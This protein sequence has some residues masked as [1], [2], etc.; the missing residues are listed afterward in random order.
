MPLTNLE[1]PPVQVPSRICATRPHQMPWRDDRR[2]VTPPPASP[3]P[4]ASEG[5]RHGSRTSPWLIAG[6]LLPGLAAVVALIFTWRQGTDTLAQGNT[7]LRIA[8]QGQITERF[9][10]A[11]E[12][13]GEDD[14][15][16]SFG[17][18]YAL[19]RIMEDS[20]RD[21]SRIVAVLSAFVRSHSRVPA[22]GF[23][24]QKA[25]SAPPALPPTVLAV[26]RVL[27]DRP[28]GRDGSAVVDWSGSD[29]RGLQLAPQSA[30][31]G[32]PPIPAA[33]FGG[34]RL[35]NSDLRGVQ[36]SKMDLSRAFLNDARL[37]GAT[38]TQVNLAGADLT[39]VHAEKATVRDSV[40][41]EA[42]LRGAQ[43]TGTN[44]VRS[45][46][47][48]AFLEEADL[49]E[50][51]FS[52]ED[53]ESSALD[54]GGQLAGASL[55]NTDLTRSRLFHADLTGANLR[56]A[57]LTAAELGGANLC[58]S[59]LNNAELSYPPDLLEGEAKI[60]ANLTGADLRHADLSHANL[61]GAFLMGADL[62]G[63]NLLSTDLTG[64]TLGGANL[65][66]V[67]L[68][69]TIGLPPG[70]DKGRPLP[71]TRPRPPCPAHTAS[72]PTQRP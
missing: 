44:F 12:R 53:G 23:A 66:D 11:I 8:E 18:V 27:A 72:T 16:L 65:T 59:V 48:G 3:R 60:G 35:K 62:R 4:R 54:K 68:S 70:A 69:N 71:P 34:A 64:A 39:K 41:K 26:I 22:G 52:S 58:N 42:I 63:A 43:L 17:G 40:L 33:P 19:E 7:E 46:L 29:L 21:Q 5:R 2:S 32:A 45:D 30:V 61:A 51:R 25:G 14:E 36:F 56:N 55:V 57:D 20:P 9:T 31:A 28:A 13:L 6:S 10:A 49:Q 38:L 50:T 67:D 1:Q 37:A 47:N 15:E 24:V